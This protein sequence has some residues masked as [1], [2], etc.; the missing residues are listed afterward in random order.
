MIHQK[1][2]PLSSGTT[3][4]LEERRGQDPRHGENTDRACFYF[5]CTA[6][7]D[8]CRKGAG[9]TE[10]HPGKH[11]TRSMVTELISFGDPGV[12]RRKSAFVTADILESS[13]KSTLDEALF[14]NLPE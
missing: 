12:E 10:L 13:S 9:K 3:A 8:G 6:Q 4:I 5:C 11:K 2:A 14:E 7:E 1:L